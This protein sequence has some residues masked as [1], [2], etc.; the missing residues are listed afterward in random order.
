MTPPIAPLRIPIFAA[1]TTGTSDAIDVSNYSNFAVYLTSVGT[2]SGGT[3]AIEE[4]DYA[5]GA[6]PYSGT[7]SRIVTINA[8]DV[9]GTGQLAYHTLY[10]CI[11]NLRIR[12]ATTITGGGTIAAVLRGN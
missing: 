4:A 3:I 8:S 9:S 7:W 2:T 10:R 5:P 11:A 6:T 1:G 12:I